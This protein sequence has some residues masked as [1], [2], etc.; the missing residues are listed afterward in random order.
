MS[1]KIIF[2]KGRTRLFNRAVS[3]WTRGPYSHCE[4]IAQEHEDG[5]VTCWSSSFQDGGVRVRRM[6]LDPDNWD[7]LVV[8]GD[9]DAAIRWF[10]AHE[11]DKYDWLALVG[12]VFRPIKGFDNRVFCNESIS[13]AIGMSDGW[14]FDPNSFHAALGLWQ[15]NPEVL[16]PPRQ[17][18]D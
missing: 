11:G 15:I 3:D 9:L 7:T 14:R 8:P 17:S 18:L 1:I 12:F 10:E 2:Y 5:S 4:L 6:V 13:E 16:I